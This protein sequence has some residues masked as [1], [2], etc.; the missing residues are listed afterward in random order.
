MRASTL[1]TEAPIAL[2]SLCRRRSTWVYFRPA[3]TCVSVVFALDWT[4]RPSLG[5]T[6]CTTSR[7][8]IIEYPILYY[9]IY[10]GTCSPAARHMLRPDRDREVL[11]W[12]CGPRV[13]AR[14]E[15]DCVR[16][17]RS[18]A[19]FVFFCSSH[20]VVVCS[21]AFVLVWRGGGGKETLAEREDVQGFLPRFSHHTM[22]LVVPFWQLSLARAHLLSSFVRRGAL[23]V[24]RA[25]GPRPG[26]AI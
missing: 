4:L 25:R 14:L 20:F 3:W 15:C 1:L 10:L 2:V 12:P 6:R 21:R 9:T 16:R 26:E 17:R 18:R 7:A 11:H 22:A 13:L 24:W 8:Q 23:H 5:W 19:P